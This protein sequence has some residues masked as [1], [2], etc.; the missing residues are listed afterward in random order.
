MTAHR[1]AA[2][3]MAEDCLCFR[4]RRVSRALTR[5]YDAALRPLGIQATQ[6]TLLN[7]VAMGGDSGTSMSPLADV[8]AMDLT[9][10]SRNVRPLENAGLVRVERSRED[11]R[12]RV[13]RLTPEGRRLVADALPRWREAHERIVAALGP[14]AAAGMREH[15]DATLAA[16]GGR[17]APSEA[18]VPAPR[19][20]ADPDPSHP[21]RAMEHAS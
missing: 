8:L 11:R 5:L 6:L 2:R 17:P 9:T 12:V 4:A 10:V 19:E 7:A 1:D 3:T 13:V 21:T 15:F 18:A 14:E 20:G 16:A